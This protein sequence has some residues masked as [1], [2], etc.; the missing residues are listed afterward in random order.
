MFFDW[1]QN[2]PRAQGFGTHHQVG[3]IA[4]DVEK[5]LPE[6]VNKGADSYLSVEYSKIVS[7]V[8]AAVKEIYAMVIGH[9]QR[10]EA[11]SREIASLNEKLT[12]ENAAKDQK[13][14]ELEDRLEKIEKALGS[15]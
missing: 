6:F 13:I 15:R 2:N 3:F 14:K 10:I 12:V 9:D 7:A 5:V 1:D 4:Q 11:Q 8:V